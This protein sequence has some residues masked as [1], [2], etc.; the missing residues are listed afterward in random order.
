M[1]LFNYFKMVVNNVSQLK[2]NQL[3]KDMHYCIQKNIQRV[4]YNTVE[5]YHFE[6]I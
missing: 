1:R 5:I 3:T 2:H 6:K 4:L